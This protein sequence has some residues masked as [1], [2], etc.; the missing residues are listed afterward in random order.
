M[1]RLAGADLQGG[2]HLVDLFGRFLGAMRQ[3]TH[4]I[5][6]HGKT[7]T[8]FAST[9]GLDGGVQGQQV[10]LL[11][12][13]FDHIE[14]LPDVV[15]AGVEGFDLLA[16]FAD[17]LRQRSHRRDGFFHHLAAV[18]GLFAGTAGVLRGIGGVAG[19][20]L[21]GGAQFVDRCSHA[22]GAHAL[23]FG[24]DDRGVGRAHYPFR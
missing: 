16:G 11:R 24:T 10:G 13:A 3:V 20:F 19:D 6:D 15:G 8:G 23:L 18:V 4:F 12:D 2:D 14:D 9:G 21:G 1:Y 22:V 7:A 17:L 5:G